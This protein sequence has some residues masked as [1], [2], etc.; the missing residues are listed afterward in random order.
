MGKTPE[1]LFQERTKR[2]DDVTKL[3][4]PDR[5]PFMPYFQFF[6]AKYVGI[7]F[8]EVMYDYEKAGQAWEKVILDLQ[9][10]MYTSP[11]TT[12]CIGPAFELLD[13]R[14]LRW[15][16]HGLAPNLAYQFVEGE[17][18]K[19]DEYDAFLFDPSDFMLRTIFPRISGAL[20]PLKLFTPMTWAYYTRI[21]A[22]FSVFGKPE[23][24]A[25]IKC[26]LEVG[27]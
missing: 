11:Y 25:A 18:M 13:Y 23:V 15:P 24:A 4:V 16:G 22:R 14:Q 10:D 7:S 20:E 17:Y 6:P 9:L 21:P 26:L 3:K 8:Q 2:I 1:E 27:A 12:Q 19:S 5:V